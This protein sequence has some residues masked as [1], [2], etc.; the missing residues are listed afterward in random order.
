M[1]MRDFTSIICN[2]FARGWLWYKDSSR[3]SWP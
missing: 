2:T 3:A 1:I